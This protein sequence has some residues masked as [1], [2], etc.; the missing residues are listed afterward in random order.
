MREVNLKVVLGSR[1]SYLPCILF[2]LQNCKGIFGCQAISKIPSTLICKQTSGHVY[3]YIL[4]AEWENA[5]F[6][7]N[8]NVTKI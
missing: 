8:S 5:R 4:N 6:Q 1:T 2:K 3:F 7:T